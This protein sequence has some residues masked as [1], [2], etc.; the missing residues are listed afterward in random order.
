MGAES[1][2]VATRGQV[3]SREGWRGLIMGQ[4]GGSSAALCHSRVTT[5]GDDIL[6]KLEGRIL[7]SSRND[8]SL[9]REVYVT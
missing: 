8:Q 3:V 9:N 4:I 6:Y 2:V 5:P 1:T 7:K